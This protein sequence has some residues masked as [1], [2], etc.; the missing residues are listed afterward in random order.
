[1]PSLMT[2]YPVRQ[3]R[4]LQKGRKTVI[5]ITLRRQE[6]QKWIEK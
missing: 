3:M 4:T 2:R 1:M 5:Q 6:F